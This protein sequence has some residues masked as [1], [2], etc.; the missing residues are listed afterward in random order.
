MGLGN[1]RFTDLDH[2]QA[3]WYQEA[4]K[5][6]GDNGDVNLRAQALIGLGNASRSMKKNEEAITYYKDAQKL[7]GKNSHLYIKASDG[8]K[9]ASMFLNYD[10]N[11]KQNLRGK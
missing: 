10:N 6:L 9:Y 1:A 8:I 2:Q 5:I 7:V 4:L 3:D 11:K